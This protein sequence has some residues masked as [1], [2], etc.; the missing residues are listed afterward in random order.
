M[1]TFSNYI[2][3]LEDHMYI[4]LHYTLKDMIDLFQNLNE[5]MKNK[6]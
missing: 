2:I 1:Y 4:S 6:H 5:E 3:S